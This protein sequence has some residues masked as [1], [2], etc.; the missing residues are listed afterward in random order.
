MNNVS[1]A[2]SVF[3]QFQSLKSVGKVFATAFESKTFSDMDFSLFLST[4]SISIC[5]KWPKF[6]IKTTTKKKEKLFY[7][8]DDCGVKYL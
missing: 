5:F 3:K 2:V 6:K 4:F 7:D 8:N 1:N